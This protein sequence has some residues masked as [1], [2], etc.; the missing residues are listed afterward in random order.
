MNKTTY[1]LTY[2]IPNAV[3]TIYLWHRYPSGLWKL[4]SCANRDFYCSRGWKS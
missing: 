1:L 2:L 3:E 4:N